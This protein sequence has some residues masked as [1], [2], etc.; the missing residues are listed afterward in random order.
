MA[1]KYQASLKRHEKKGRCKI[2]KHW[3][4]VNKAR[5]KTISETEV[6]SASSSCDDEDFSSL[7]TTTTTNPKQPLFCD[8]FLGCNLTTINNNNLHQ[9]LAMADPLF[10]F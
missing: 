1:F 3:C 4:P 10:S 7:K 8:V 5:R 6:S 9:S 2:G